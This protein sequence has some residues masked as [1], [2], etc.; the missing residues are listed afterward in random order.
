MEAVRD[1]AMQSLWLGSNCESAAAHTFFDSHVMLE[2][3]KIAEFRTSHFPLKQLIDV[4]QQANVP[5]NGLVKEFLGF[6]VLFHQEQALDQYKGVVVQAFLDALWRNPTTHGVV[7]SLR[8]MSWKL[9]G[10]SVV[11]DLPGLRELIQDGIS[12]YR[13]PRAAL[14]HGKRRTGI[15]PGTRADGC[16]CP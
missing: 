1:Q 10:L 12:G 11:T 6:F 7:L 13:R 4:F 5:G 15:D 9:F 16:R 3:A 2:C 14:P 8:S